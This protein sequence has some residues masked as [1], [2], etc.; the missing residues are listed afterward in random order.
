MF[1]TE[2]EDDNLLGQAL[3]FY[4]AGLEAVS[5]AIAFSLY[6]LSRHTEYQSQLYEEIK[7]HL[8]NEELTLESINKMEFLDQVVNETLRLYP[9]LPMIDRIA[10]K[11]Y[12]VSYK[13]F[14]I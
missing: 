11:N 5:S 6:E 10:S 12:K 3:S 7:I 8:N 13:N 9:P 1:L 4:I 2:F 14:N